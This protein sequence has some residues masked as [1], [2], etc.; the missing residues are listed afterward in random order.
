MPKLENGM[1]FNLLPMDTVNVIDDWLIGLENYKIF[2][3]VVERIKLSCSNI[4]HMLKNQ[5]WV[6]YLYFGNE[7]IYQEKK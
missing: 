5:H 2:K 1:L 3:P 6:P 7:L 4:L